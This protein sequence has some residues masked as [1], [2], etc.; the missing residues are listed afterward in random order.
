MTPPSSQAAKRRE[1][2]R[3][4]KTLS[5]PLALALMCLIAYAS[6]YPFTDW[7][8]QGISPLRFLTAPL[9]KYWTGFDVGVNL[10]GYAP[11][12]FLLVLS[13]YSR[14]VPWPVSVAV[15]GAGLLSL[16]METLQSYLPS[17]VPSNVD[18]I[19]NTLGGWL[20]AC[21][22]WALERVG[23][24]ER[25]RQVRA[26]WVAPDARGALVLLL[27]WPPALLFPAAVP[28]GLG[29][30]FER[31]ES[32]LADALADTP[33]LEWMPVREVELQPLVPMAELICVTLGALIP[34]L[35]G[36]C[37]IRKLGSRAAF[38]AAAI[39]VGIAASALSAALSYGPQHAWAWLDLPVQVGL[40]LTALL[41]LLL[42]AVPQ[43][44]A[45]ALT[46]LALAT[47]LGL[48]NQAPADP[49]F[50]Q[51]LQIWEQGRFIHFYGLVQ[52]LGWLWPYAA[53]LYVLV[54]LS[55]REH[56]GVTET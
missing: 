36:Y 32:A 29:Q 43:R 10:L 42:L 51:T 40:G 55:G 1:D 52:W 14:R 7:R 54:R 38:A 30:V 28:M 33:F 56:A 17:R 25:W 34:C 2:V 48:L 5:W 16:S 11:L 35:L 27:F 37:V 6:L 13:A 24:V 19:L 9:P 47:H 8:N 45:A 15:L 20:G 18:L 31:L 41:A 46:L 39:A 44:A 26:R 49:Y 23:L 4:V 12:G 22:A 3:G 21:C 50:A 53:L